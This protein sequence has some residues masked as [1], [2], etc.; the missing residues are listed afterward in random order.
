VSLYPSHSGFKRH[1]DPHH[2]KF[3]ELIRDNRDKL[4]STILNIGLDNNDG[5]VPSWPWVEWMLNE[6]KFDK[7]VVLEYH[8]PNVEFHRKHFE[9]EPR[10]KIIHGD[11]RRAASFV[12]DEIDTVF[13]WHGPEHIP[14]EDLPQSYDQLSLLANKAQFWACPW[15][16]YY[17]VAKGRF[18]GDEHHYFPQNEHFES[19]GLTVFNT[20]GAINTGHANIVAYEIKE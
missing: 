6:L 13:W 18:T 20:G 11:V 16:N 17:G 1:L 8:K 15:G 3:F 19:L 7:V 14:L 10:V 9:K 2:I 5:G 4:G 12:T